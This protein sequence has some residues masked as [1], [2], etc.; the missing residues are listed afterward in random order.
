MTN[1]LILRCDAD[2]A[3]VASKERPE[4]SGTTAVRASRLPRIKSGVAPQH[5]GVWW[6][7]P[8]AGRVRLILLTLLLCVSPAAYAVQPDEMLADPALEARAR[9]ISE[10]LRCLVCQ[11]QSIDDSNAPLAHDLRLLVRER[12]K[13]GDSNDAVRKYL[14]ARYGDFILLKP[15]FEVRTLILWLT[16]FAV[17]AIGALV[18][19]TRARRG[20]TQGPALSGEEEA[21]VAR[22]LKQE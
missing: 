1:P 13:A 18:A 11:N 3:G 6:L 8:V 2:V 12:L 21:A 10:G 14:V 19:L 4:G 20:E 17:L 5:E 16:P 9:E 7:P 15:P 22:I